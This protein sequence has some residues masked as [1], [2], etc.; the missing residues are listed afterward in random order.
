MIN[1]DTRDLFPTSGGKLCTWVLGTD[2]RLCD[3]CLQDL[4]AVLP[5]DQKDWELF[6]CRSEPR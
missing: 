4:S 6:V 5:A 2:G 3:C 1:P